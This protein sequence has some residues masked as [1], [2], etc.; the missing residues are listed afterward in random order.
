MQPRWVVVAWEPGDTLLVG[1]WI[2]VPSAALSDITSLDKTIADNVCILFIL[3]YVL[4]I[5]EE[6]TAKV[7]S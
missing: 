5:L 4:N 1:E 3:M 6:R 7:V 2:G